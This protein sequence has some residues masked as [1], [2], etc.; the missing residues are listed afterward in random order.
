MKI[1]SNIRI[2]GFDYTVKSV[3]DVP[4]IKEL[5]DAELSGSIDFTDQ[6]ILVSNKYPEDRQ[7]ETTLHETIHGIVF[8]YNIPLPSKSDEAIVVKLGQG[9]FQVLKDNPDLRK[10][11]EKE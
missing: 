8:H 5:G 4:K 11:F 10:I 7:I 9:L 3:E 6:E 2:A 1:P